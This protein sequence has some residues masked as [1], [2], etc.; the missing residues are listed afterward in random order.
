MKIC[1]LNG[2][3]VNYD[4]SVDYSVLGDSVTVH[5]DCT[6]A[7]YYGFSDGYDVIVSKELPMSY[8]DIMSLP[9]SV[10]LIAEAGTGYN[11]IDL[12]ACRERGIGLI[13]VP[14]YSSERVS[15]TAIMMMLCFASS[16]QK[17]FSMLANDD[18][19]NFTDKL[20]VPHFEV[21]GK[22][23][24]VIGTGNIGKKTIAIGKALDMRVIA[25][26]PGKPNA[27]VEYVDF[28]TLLK[29]SDFVFL[30]CPLNESTR[31]MIDAK[32]LS[33]MKPGACIINTAR[34][35]LIDEQALIDALRENRI[36]G[37][38]LDVQ[39][40]EPL[41]ENS[42]LFELDNVILTP[43]MGW[44]GLETRQRLIGILR[45]G[46]ASFENGGTLNRIV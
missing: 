26:K 3:K 1:V 22:T 27:D 40:N 45:D 29:E 41:A 46:I 34:G 12:N 2:K 39:E 32:A 36:G 8:D 19:S 7:D 21:N 18:R 4:G 25:Y 33:L 14:A 15:H 28:D 23:M 38:C 10:K 37:A 42:P 17:Q 43:H 44:K 11:N 24:G 31:H 35:A 13:N 9:V 30:H 5:D 6:P 20:S 16:M